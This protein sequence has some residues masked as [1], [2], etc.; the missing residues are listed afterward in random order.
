MSRIHAFRIL[1]GIAWVGLWAVLAYRQ[2]LRYPLYRKQAE[3]NIVRAIPLPAPRAL[4]LDRTG[5]VI[6]GYGAGVV[7]VRTSRTSQPP[8]ETYTPAQVSY[9]PQSRVVP[10]EEAVS[11]V[12]SIHRYPGILPL[13]FPLRR[14]DRAEAVAHVVGYVGEAS[15]DTAWGRFVGKMG[16]EKSE[17]PRLV[18][19]DGVRFVQVDARGHVRQWDV[20]PPTPPRIPP[21]LRLSVDM[22][23][24]EK[25]R[26]LLSG[27]RG[28]A[29]MMDVRTGELLL[30]YSSPTFDP[31]R[32]LSPQRGAY[33]KTLLQDPGRPLL[34][35]ALQGLYPPGSTFKVLF[36]L[37]ALKYG[38]VDPS[39]KLAF[40]DGTYTLG[41]R[42]WKCW[43][44]AGHGRLNMV[45]AIAQ[46][47]DVYFYDLA[48]RMGLGGTLKVLR[49]IRNALDSL[50]LPLYEGKRGRVPTR[51]TY[52]RRYGP[53]P[54]EGLAL[55]LAIGQGEVL[56]TPLEMMVMAGWV[57]T[58][59]A[60]PMPHLHAGET[61]VRVLRLDAP[62]PAWDVVAR[63]MWKVVNDSS[64]TAFGARIPGLVYAG[65]TGTVQNP[66]GDEHSLFI[67]Y[68][69]YDRPRVAFAVVVENAGHGSEVAAP[70][71]RALLETF[72]AVE[73]ADTGTFRGETSQ[74]VPGAP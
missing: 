63:G 29:V 27:Y 37:L 11:R 57:A 64:G 46:S 45:D 28:A 62:D 71:A 70:I 23:L 72:F 50:D 4:I 20:L 43:D 52:E 53:Q 18:G 65:K 74:T 68:A 15:A 36:A 44:P 40:C 34:N 30:L 55:N 48:R 61:S 67:G 21:P 13:L 47:C 49:E 14:Y 38:W 6:A 56:M 60:L 22:R 24:Q 32:F 51:E 31:Q 3:A 1:V 35:R 58:R 66:H 54:P 2:I 42:T 39:E 33:W 69:P 26:E 10:L 25:A 9:I 73:R 8:F 17:E 59:G 41:R 5:R 16:V 12:E 7:F 19:Q